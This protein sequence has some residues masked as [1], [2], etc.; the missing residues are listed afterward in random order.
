MQTRLSI[1]W[2]G[3][4]C[5]ERGS[6]WRSHGVV[7]E[8]VVPE[9]VVVVEEIV[10][11]IDDQITEAIV[12]EVMEGVAVVEAEASVTDQD[13]GQERLK[14]D[15]DALEQR[16]VLPQ[17]IDQDLVHLLPENRKDR[18]GMER[19][20]RDLQEVHQDLDP[21]LEVLHNSQ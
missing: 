10:L 3:E 1:Q 13:P 16:A 12:I 6:A 11:V 5:A 20:R 19:T 15:A 17:K 9:V 18:K 4:V 21:D 2:M 14:E 8:A 7:V